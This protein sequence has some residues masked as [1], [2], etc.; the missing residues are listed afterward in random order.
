MHVFLTGASGYL[1][2]RI[3][4]RLLS[5]GHTVTGL[6]RRAGSAPNGVRERIGDLARPN[7][8]L[9]AVSEADATIH[10]AFGH[11]VEFGDAVETERA[12]LDAM[13]GALPVNGTLIATSAAGVLGDTGP[14]P[15]AD[16]ASV[17]ADFPARIRG[18]VED[19]VR[20]AG[21][22][23]PR[24]IA[25]R[26]PVLVHGHGGSPF[27]PGLIE[28]A[29]RDG[30]SRFVGGGDNRMSTVH[31]DDAA[32]AYVTALD[33]G[34]P[35]TVYNVAGGRVTGREL[36]EAVA[37]NV[38]TDHVEGVPLAD[39]Q[40]VLHPFMALLISMNFDLDAGR[41]RTALDWTPQGP[42]L[43]TDVERGSYA[44]LLTGR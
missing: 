12:A 36:A 28:A 41:T 15:T 8:F 4:E 34:Q 35:G 43:P 27:L 24:L 20:H 23:G 3:A 11:D 33:R 40:R 22:D 9:D 26:L 2:S 6:V 19:R 21:V 16:K 5:G 18:F 25:M 31:V 17:S 29:R 42:D 32:D 38:G 7:E 30:V 10:T 14:E 39:A 13:L 1:G 37:R 44:V